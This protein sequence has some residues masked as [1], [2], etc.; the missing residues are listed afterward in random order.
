MKKIF[1]PFLTVCLLVTFLCSCGPKLKQEAGLESNNDA[2]WDLIVSEN[3][4]E[5][6]SIEFDE[7]T[8]LTICGSYYDGLRIFIVL[9][10]KDDDIKNYSEK[11]FF[12]RQ[13][14]NTAIYPNWFSVEDNKIYLIFNC[15]EASNNTCLYVVLNDKEYY[16]D[17]F[18]INNHS[19]KTLLPNKSFEELQLTKVDIAGH[20]I[21][22]S[23]VITG[24]ID[25]DNVKIEHLPNWVCSAHFF[26]K[27]NISENKIEFQ[28]LFT[29]LNKDEVKFNLITNDINELV[30]SVIPFELEV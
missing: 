8:H 29:I 30:T 15:Y 23:G 24:H 11:D 19:K 4:L 21:L 2:G 27:K 17:N 9:E 13:E 3:L 10:N 16:T 7:L 6:C 18:I 26:E 20:S 25:I 5:K 12:V 28:A 1:V 22:I 14:D